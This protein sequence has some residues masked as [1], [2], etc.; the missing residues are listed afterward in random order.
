MLCLFE[1]VSTDCK[2]EP[3]L[4]VQ[5]TMVFNI[6]KSCIDTMALPPV[7]IVDEKMTKYCRFS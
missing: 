2:L 4:L 3:L 5:I 6:G 7:K 1:S